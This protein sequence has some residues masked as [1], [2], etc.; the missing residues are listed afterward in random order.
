MKKGDRLTRAVALV[1]FVAM[2]CYLGF[3]LLRRVT[4]P[5][6]SSPAVET[7]L[8][9]SAS[10]TGIVIRDERL[11]LSQRS[12]IDLLAG[13]GEKIA[14]DGAVAMAYRSEEALDRA[15]QLQGLDRQRREAREALQQQEA[16][17]GSA[18]VFAAALELSGALRSE[19][20]SDLDLKSDTMAAL[21]HQ[22]PGE[23]LTVE[24]LMALEQEYESLQTRA[25]QDAMTIRA[26]SAGT[27]SSILDGYEDLR[28]EAAA[29]LTPQSLDQLLASERSATEGAVGKMIGSHLWY[30]AGKLS[31]P[32][33]QALQPGQE[34][35][36]SFGRYWAETLEAEVLSVSEAS[37]GQCVVLFRLD[38]ALAELLAVRKTGAELVYGRYEGLRVPQEGL[39]RYYAGYLEASEAGALA[40]GQEVLLE[41]TGFSVPARISEL[42]PEEAGRRQVVL[43]WPW[44]EDNALPETGAA[45]LSVEGRSLPMED[46]YDRDERG[47]CLCVFTLTGLQAERKKVSLAWAAESFCLVQSRGEDALRAG[48]DILV[49]APGLYNGKVFD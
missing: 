6:R 4:R 7:S 23:S 8:T 3:A 1:L 38:E 45:V 15:L 18:G 11:I 33:A 47:D 42:G 26:E 9:E 28:P 48:N 25:R 35:E 17:E 41:G 2:L 29:L 39:W 21:L 37:G 40:P 32:E 13:D 27:F 5:V 31:A 30:Y 34:V 22:N 43:F 46:H 10:M 36:L 44:T 19:D 16:S 24:Y 14:A 49:E 20:Y 12:Y